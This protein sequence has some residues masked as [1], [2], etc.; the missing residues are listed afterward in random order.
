ME[1][2]SEILWWGASV[3]KCL[4]GICVYVDVYVYVMYMLVFDFEIEGCF[5]GPSGF[6]VSLRVGRMWEVEEEEEREAEEEAES[7]RIASKL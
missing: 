6:W 2:V 3:A 1:S 4:L 7:G 5:G